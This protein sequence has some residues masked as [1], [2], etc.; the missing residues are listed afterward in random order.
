M[1]CSS[2]FNIITRNKW[3][4]NDNMDKQQCIVNW[5]ILFKPTVFFCLLGYDE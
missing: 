4:M 1:H 2:F 5:F 3:M